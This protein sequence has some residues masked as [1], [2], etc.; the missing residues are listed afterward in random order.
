MDDGEPASRKLRILLIAYE[1]PPSPSPQSL[2]WA[3]FSNRLAERGHEVHVMTPDVPG[4]FTGLPDPGP[5]VTVHR[6]YPG[7]VRALL[8]RLARRRPVSA[9]PAP[10]PAG[11]DG[12]TA[13][14]LAIDP[15]R[16]N[17]KGR[18]IEGI[19]HV[20]SWMIFPDLRGEWRRPALDVLPDLLEQIRPDV[21]VSS[22]EPAT[23]LQVG[24]TAKAAGYPWVA[25]LGDPVVAGYTPRRWLRKAED[26][27]GTVLEQAD[28]V[29]VTTEATAALLRKRHSPAAPISVVEQGFD[30]HFDH[31]TPDCR[32]GGDLELLYSGRFYS[33][34]DPTILVK[35]VLS[36]PNIRLTVASSNVPTWLA[37]AASV[38]PDRLRL[39]GRVAHRRL[40]GLQRSADVLVN[41]ANSDPAQVP[42]KFYEYLGALRPI[43]H[44]ESTQRDAAVFL[45]AQLRRGWSVAGAHGPLS[46]LLRELREAKAS[47][48][49][50]DGR[51]LSREPVMRW[52]WG[53]G[54]AKVEQVLMRAA[55]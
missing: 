44:V 16:L 12:E 28:H 52:S 21:V 3:Y 8:G 11:G 55:S 25:D 18:L 40:L 42:G 2:R 33:F 31:A 5:N 9:E 15:P 47:G 30:E 36:I 34:R 7:P 20:L 29:L 26:L 48:S 39:L 51:D 4:T 13:A 10:E 23:S 54:G 24:L 32:Q 37:E 22:H 38:N 6:T 27:E 17:W 1:F 43:L 35:A 46:A 50:D 14:Q 41:L 49:L 19:Q 53:A 45:L